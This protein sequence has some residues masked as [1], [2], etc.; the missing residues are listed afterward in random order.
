M[1]NYSIKNHKL[2]K[3]QAIAII[4]VVAVFTLLVIY[5]LILAFVR[6]GKIATEVR[7]A[8]YKTTITLNDKRISN[9]GKVYLTPGTYHLKATFEHFETYEQDVTISETYHALAGVLIPSDEEGEAYR[10]KYINQ[11]RY[12]EGFIGRTIN[13]EGAAIQAKYPIMA[14]LPITNNLYAITYQRETPESEPVINI[15]TTDEFIDVAVARLK[16]F[17]DVEITDLNLTFST[18]FSTDISTSTASSASDFVR[19]SISGNYVV[20]A[21]IEL[22]DQYTMIKIYSYNPNYG[23]GADYGHYRVILSKKGNTWEYATPIYPLFTTKNAPDIP[24]DIL[25][26]ANE[27]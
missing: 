24:V 25:K 19:E 20:S 8:P 15:R 13:E 27:K 3:K 2:D 4:V 1:Q 17:K 6:T 12:V 10:D 14:H 5:G 18:D 22:S 9:N 16:S 23:R 26:T 21:P 7:F 11:F